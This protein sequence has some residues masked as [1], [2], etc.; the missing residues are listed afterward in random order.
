MCHVSKDPAPSSGMKRACHSIREFFRGRH[1]AR[2]C[3]RKLGRQGRTRLLVQTLAALLQVSLSIISP[4][5]ASEK[6]SLALANDAMF[7]REEVHS[8]GCF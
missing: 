7:F 8:R 3:D 6:I 5:V 1:A 4:A 2:R